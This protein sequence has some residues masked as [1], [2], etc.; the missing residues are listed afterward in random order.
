MNKY[1]SKVSSLASRFENEDAIIS[2]AQ[3]KWDEK[4]N[5]FSKNTQIDE[6]TVMSEPIS[7]EEYYKN[8]S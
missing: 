5:T 6:N 7:S 1:M 4:T 2:E 3:Y 8:K